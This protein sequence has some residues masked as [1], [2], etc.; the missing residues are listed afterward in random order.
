MRV[1]FLKRRLLAPKEFD[2]ANERAEGNRRMPRKETTKRERER[3]K[4]KGQRGTQEEERTGG[5]RPSSGTPKTAPANSKELNKYLSLRFGL[6]Y[7]TDF[8]S[9]FMACKEGRERSRWALEK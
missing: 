8:V 2:E 5:S 6:F 7:L 4:K 3:E 1:L 9:S